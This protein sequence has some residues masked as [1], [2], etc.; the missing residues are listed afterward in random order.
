MKRIDL[1]DRYDVVIV[2][3]GPAGAATARALRGQGLDVVI[4]EKHRLPRHK[5]CS[6][7]LFPIAVKMV[8]E[9]FGDIPESVCCAPVQLKG[10]R[11]FL[12]NE[13]PFLEWPFLVRGSVAEGMNISRSE[14]DA[15]LC[16]SSGTA[17]SDQ[18]RFMGLKEQE[19][20][21]LVKIRQSHEERE[22]V[23]NYLIGADG[24]LSRV[25]NSLAP[26]FDRGIGLIP[27]YEEWYSG[28]IDLEP[29]WLYQFFDRSVTGFFA[30]V[31]HKDDQII[32]TTGCQTKDAVKGLFQDFVS[33]LK[34]RHGLKIR[35][36]TQRYGCVIHDM[37]G[38][39]NYFLGQGNV[40]L[41]G[42]AAGFN[43]CA[44][45][46]TSAL[47][48]GKAAGEAILRGMK[49]GQP[50]I[51]LYAKTAGLEMEKCN[52]AIQVVEKA[53]GFNPFTRD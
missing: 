52:K 33:H 25:R 19:G 28:E 14:F 38:T 36:I 13:G 46:I 22:I 10:N 2:G 51:D 35:E 15:W 34:E 48:S 11:A 4:L 41:V 40:L 12:A 5:M 47:I 26:T 45:G 8:H 44:E 50:V 43:R 17:I 18:C 30:C 16:R 1:K 53:I 3:S 39:N 20:K 6:G 21:F 49:T 37:S 32:V 23:A 24:T 29:Q 27:N 42:E 7:I 9:N 31:F